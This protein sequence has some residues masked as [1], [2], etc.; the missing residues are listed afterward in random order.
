MTK[1][2]L[3]ALSSILVL[4]VFGQQTKIL[5]AEK[6][7]EYGLVYSLPLTA[8]RITVT[9]QKETRI[10]GP[11]NQYSKRYIGTS[12]V[13][14]ENSVN[15][16]ITDIK[17][18]PFGVKDDANQYLMQLKAGATTFIGVAS[19]GMILSIN[20]TPDVEIP[21]G[22]GLQQFGSRLLESD[23]S[24]EDYL[25]YVN[26]DYLSAQNSMRQ[27][28]MLA[29]NRMDVIEAYNELISGT[30]DNMPETQGQ[31]EVMTEK[32]AEQRD[33]MTRAFTGSITREEFT[34][35]YVYI[36][37]SEGEA[38]LFR[39]SDFNGLV[40][41]DD[42]SGSPVYINVEITNEG[43]LP[44]DPITSEPKAFPKDGVVYAV[45]GS[46]KVSIYTSNKALYS[47]EFEFSQFGT[48]FGLAPT[49]FTD[50]KNPSYARFSPVTGA[51]IEIGT[52][53]K[54]VTK[55]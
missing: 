1:S 3:I 40:D 31:L 39:M 29:N 46:A 54:S 43:S 12:N 32:L 49:L 7:N 28:E 17:V 15:W 6:H 55:E 14:S 50:K 30:S 10:A 52:A 25:N 2:F 13:I 42:Y 5:T 11:Y 8:L 24:V 48:T 33:A 34:S 35:E 51:L 21:V 47:N 44:L 53:P 20:A 45:P 23:G 27:A 9:A 19:D 18:A 37:D 22:T 36:P 38:V 41:H 26:Q 4:P 16:T